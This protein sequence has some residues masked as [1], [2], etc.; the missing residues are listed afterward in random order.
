MTEQKK[1]QVRTFEGT[2][3]SVPDL[4]TATVSVTRTVVHPK[5]G[6]RYERS[7]KYR[8]H[9]VR[10]NISVGSRVRIVACKPYSKTKR[11]VIESVIEKG[12]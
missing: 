5:Y 1:V 2:V 8:C 12:V 6:K 4:K 7:K 10:G 11:W 9:V 3:V